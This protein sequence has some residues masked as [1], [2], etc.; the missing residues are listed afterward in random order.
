MAGL[1]CQQGSGRLKNSK[2]M[3]FDFFLRIDVTLSICPSS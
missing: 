1:L 3:I 2:E